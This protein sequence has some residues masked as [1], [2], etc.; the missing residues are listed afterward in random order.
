MC[1]HIPP[2]LSS[3]CFL[4]GFSLFR[5]FFLSLLQV[6][7]RTLLYRFAAEFL[8]VGVVHPSSPPFLDSLLSYLISSPSSDPALRDLSFEAREELILQIVKKHVIATKQQQHD[9]EQTGNSAS[10]FSSSSSSSFSFSSSS[11]SS[12]CLSS[13][14]S[15]SSSSFSSSP[16]SSSSSFSSTS[17]SSSSSSSFS[18]SLSVHDLCHQTFSKRFFR[19]CLCLARAVC[20]DYPLA[21]QC[22]LAN[23][24]ATVRSSVFSFVHEVMHDPSIPPTQQ[25]VRER[26]KRATRARR[27]SRKQ[28]EQRK[29]RGGGALMST[30]SP[31]SSFWTPTTVSSGTEC[32]I[33]QTF[34]VTPSHLVSS[35]FVSFLFLFFFSSFLSLCVRD[36]VILVAFICRS[37]SHARPRVHQQ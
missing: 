2:L 10:S 9:Q 8:S 6:F 1:F 4:L 30:L 37:S 14:A 18:S 22:Y 31:V 26:K 23:D 35:P 25:Q 36:I 24:S 13:P 33:S 32:I 7:H 19:V 29:G 3:L 5:F 12:F 20:R 21:L 17:S 15:T 16:F 27:E 11:S 34:P 28:S